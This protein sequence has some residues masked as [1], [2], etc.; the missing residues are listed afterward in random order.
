VQQ[1]FE[2]SE[3]GGS[4]EDLPA[5]PGPVGQTIRPQRF[6]APAGDEL[7]DDIRTD[8]DRARQ[9]I[10]INNVEAEAGEHG[11]GGGLAATNATGEP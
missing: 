1:G 7:L 10:C 6:P 9:L 2:K 4:P 3:F 5:N 8:Q 11:Q